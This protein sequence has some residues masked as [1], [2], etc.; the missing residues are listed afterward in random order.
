MLD[1]SIPLIVA[2]R[3][4]SRLISAY[5]GRPGTDPAFTPFIVFD[6]RTFDLPVGQVR[7]LWPSDALAQ[8]DAQ[9]TAVEAEMRD[10]LLEACRSL[11]ARYAAH[12]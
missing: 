5:I 2:A 3:E 7:K 6:D 12:E 8:K 11:V 10:E 1:G 9:L 4:I